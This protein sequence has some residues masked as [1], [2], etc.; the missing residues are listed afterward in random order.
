VI[1]E[2]VTDFSQD[3]EQEWILRSVPE[4]GRFLDIGAWHATK[5]SNVRALFLQGWSGVL[6][7]PHP[8]HAARLRRAYERHAPSVVVLECAV[9]LTAGIRTLHATQD[10]VSTMDPATR[11]KW[12]EVVAYDSDLLVNCATL[13][14]VYDL[15]GPFDFV[16]I[17]AEGLS[18]DLAVRLFELPV[19]LPECLCVEFDAQL[20]ELLEAAARARYRQVFANGTNVVLAAC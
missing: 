18:V 4:V 3:G 14:Q 10:A 19:R 2:H 7:E 6:V 12:S 13:E 20:G 8:D 1:A 11:Q 9:A 17:D 15:G 16:S 5:F